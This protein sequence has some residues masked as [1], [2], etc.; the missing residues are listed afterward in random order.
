MHTKKWDTMREGEREG[1][2]GDWRGRKWRVRE[3]NWSA[4]EEKEAPACDFIVRKLSGG[5]HTTIEN[6]EWPLYWRSLIYSLSTFFSILFHSFSFIFS[7]YYITYHISYFISL[8]P[9]ISLAV[10]NFCSYWSIYRFLI[11]LKK[12]M[13]WLIMW[14][15]Q[16]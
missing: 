10:M 11:K 3:S 14:W 5:T 6:Y 1:K 8:P 2:F 13:I 7:L 4:R 12:W 9:F 15:E 16:E